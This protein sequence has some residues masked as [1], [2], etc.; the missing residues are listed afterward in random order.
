MSDSF[1]IGDL[2]SYDFS[3]VK[4]PTVEKHGIVVDIQQR[5]HMP[6][7]YEVKWMNGDQ[8]AYA[9]YVLMMMAQGGL[10]TTEVIEQSRNKENG[11]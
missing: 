4:V 2:V 5:D 6:P 1:N 7:L 10:Q 3:G 11:V 8:A 9:A